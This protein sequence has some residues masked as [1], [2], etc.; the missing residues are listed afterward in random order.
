MKWMGT[1]VTCLLLL[2]VETLLLYRPAKSAHAQAQT[3]TVHN[4]SNVTNNAVDGR[5]HP[6]LIKDKDAYRL[7]F[8]AASLQDNSPQELARQ[9]AMFASLNLSD[10]QFAKVNAILS[11]FK[12]VHNMLIQDFNR[13][14][15]T[16][17]T[18]QTTG[19]LAPFIQQRDGIV[20]QTRAE[21]ELVI[22]QHASA[23]LNSF[24]QGE[25]REMVLGAD[26]SGPGN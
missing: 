5:I 8:V 20:A 17:R 12:S 23:I 21:I 2:L 6:E 15:G 26:D 3:T 1:V 7:F 22:G 25:K 16:S 9:R 14:R 19:T 10:A 11:D 4:H 18:S 13:E 24:I